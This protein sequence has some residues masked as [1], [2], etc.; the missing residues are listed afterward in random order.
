MT[1]R[2][3]SRD[4]PG[5]EM[6]RCTVAEAARRLGISESGV[7][8]RIQRG[9]IA[10]EHSAD[11]RVWVWVSPGEEREAEVRDEPPQSHDR[12]RVSRDEQVE[13]LRDQVRYLREQL[14]RA[15]ERDREN[16]RIIAALT[17][18][19]PE[20]PS[21]LQ[22]EPTPPSEPHSSRR[23][24]TVTPQPG[25]VGPQTE[26]GAAQESAEAPGMPADEQQGRGPVPDA[27]GPQ[28]G[29]EHVSWWRRMFGG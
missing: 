3:Q 15:D 26:V 11:G 4:Q 10:Y 24:Y 13:D 14:D 21:P 29:A 6:I 9:Q 28:E 5:D 20:L 7:R 1:E 2:D 18:R 22:E 16:R 19:I 23:E 12:D 8:K 17:Q 25:R 27:G